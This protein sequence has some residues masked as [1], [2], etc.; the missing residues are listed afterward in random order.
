MPCLPDS[1]HYFSYLIVHVSV[2]HVIIYI[3]L[4]VR[5]LWYWIH[6]DLSLFILDHW[7][8]TKGEIPHINTREYDYL[9][10]YDAVTME[11]ILFISTRG[12]LIYHVYLVRFKPY[13]SLTQFISVFCSL[14]SQTSCMYVYFNLADISN[15]CMNNIVLLTVQSPEHCKRLKRLFHIPFYHT[16]FGFSLHQISVIECLCIWLTG[17]S[18]CVGA[19]CYC[20][21]YHII[22]MN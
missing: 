4:K 7:I 10:V 2:V 22:L 1:V 20:F 19:E 15:Q 17:N 5:F 6:H 13:I 16:F 14:M 9:F 8:Y 18:V 3:I 12:F 11:F 21:F